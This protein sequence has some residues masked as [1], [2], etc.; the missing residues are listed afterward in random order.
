MHQDHHSFNWEFEIRALA[1]QKYFPAIQQAR[2]FLHLRSI[3]SSVIPWMLSSLL[4]IRFVLLLILP[5]LNYL[6]FWCISCFSLIFVIFF[7][8]IRWIYCVISG[9]CILGFKVWCVFLHEYCVQ[10]LFFLI[11]YELFDSLF[12]VFFFKNIFFWTTLDAWGEYYIFSF[13]LV[14]IHRL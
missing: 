12:E 11:F 2:L 5:A 9:F 3:L 4:S 7:R 10:F 6:G 13:F 1:S 8:C 14:V